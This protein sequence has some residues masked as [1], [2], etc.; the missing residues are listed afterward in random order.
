[1]SHKDRRRRKRDCNGNLYEPRK[2]RD[3]GK[4]AHESRIGTALRRTKWRSQGFMGRFKDLLT[5]WR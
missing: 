2:K 4:Q 1:M 3:A 5:F